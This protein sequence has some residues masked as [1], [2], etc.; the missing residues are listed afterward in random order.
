MSEIDHADDAVDH[1]VADRDQ[2]IDRAEHEAV[3]ELLGE[4]IHGCQVCATT[5]R[6]PRAALDAASC[7][8]LTGGN[9]E[10]Q[11]GWPSSKGLVQVVFSGVPLPRRRQAAV[12]LKPSWNPCSPGGRRIKVNKG[13]TLPVA[14]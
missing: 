9:P 5:R 7:H 6:R 4:I 8:F 14:V 11:Q 10:R 1:G 12:T 13:F 2:P 3:D